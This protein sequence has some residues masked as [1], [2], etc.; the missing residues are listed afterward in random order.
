MGSP[1][2]NSRKPEYVHKRCSHCSTELEFQT[3]TSFTNASP[4][5]SVKCHSCQKISQFSQETPI[6]NSNATTNNN[7]PNSN[8]SKKS[9]R[10]YGTA[11]EPLETELYDILGVI[12]SD[13]KLRERYNEYGRNTEVMPEGGFVNPEDFF[14]QQ[15]G[16]E[17]FVD[18]IGEI[19]IGRDMKEVLQNAA[20]DDVPN[21]ELT[22]E[23][24][25]RRESSNSTANS[26]ALDDEREKI[27]QQRIGKL[28]SNLIEKLATYVGENGKIGLDPKAFKE[29]VEYEAEELK[30]ES[31]GVELLH[32]IGFTYS[33]K[34]K[35]YLAGEQILGLPRLGHILREKGHVFSETIS[36]LK[37]ALDL[38]QSF[39]Q[40][41][42]AE[43]A[44]VGSKLEVESV[45]REVCDRVLS[46]PAIPKEI[47]VKRAEGLKIIGAV[48]ENVKSE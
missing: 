12:L 26:H 1:V 21:E 31:Y 14:R 36:T 41:Q 35:Q 40:L 33:L 37:S 9:K 42:K 4:Q 29:R 20:T 6:N 3:P 7:S 8:G 22:E 17:R 23:E 48:Y 39:S 38:Q 16:G 13:P 43:E 2:I 18:I 28:V 19:S 10:V 45:L 30:T 24:K 46:D 15:F 44:G 32:A 47:L 5:Y 27:R 34:A 11:K 25:S